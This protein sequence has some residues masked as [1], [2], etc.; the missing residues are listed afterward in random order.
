MGWITGKSWVDSCQEQE[1]DFS[2]LKIVHTSPEGKLHVQ[3]EP[4]VYFAGEKRPGREATSHFPV[5]PRLRM[6]GVIPP[7]PHISV[8]SL[9]SCLPHFCVHWIVP[10]KNYALYGGPNR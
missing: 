8:F 6:R 10:Q 3:L 5:V 4:G 2:A 9:L 7:F 1:R